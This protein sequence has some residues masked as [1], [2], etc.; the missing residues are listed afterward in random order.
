[1]LWTKNKILTTSSLFENEQSAATSF[2]CS[3][4]LFDPYTV[5]STHYQADTKFEELIV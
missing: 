1:M 5:L 3:K 2:S 4:I